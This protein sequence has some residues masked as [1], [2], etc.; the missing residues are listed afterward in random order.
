MSGTGTVNDTDVGPSGS[1]AA[2]PAPGNSC[3]TVNVENPD[4]VGRRRSEWMIASPAVIT[5]STS[6]PNAAV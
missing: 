2:E 1:G 3:A 5:S 4:V 6:A